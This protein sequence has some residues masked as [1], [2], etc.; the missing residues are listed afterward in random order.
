[1][2]AEE[3]RQSAAV[4][5]WHMVMKLWDEAEVQIDD[6]CRMIKLSVNTFSQLK[7]QGRTFFAYRCRCVYSLSF[8]TL[9]SEARDAHRY[10]ADFENL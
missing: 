5:A 7:S 10:M 6:S 1:M 8:L 3:E 9:A 4:R 2:S